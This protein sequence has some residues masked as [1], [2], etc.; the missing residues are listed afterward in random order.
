MPLSVKVLAEFRFVSLFCCCPGVHLSTVVIKYTDQFMSGLFFCSFTN[1]V[2]PQLSLWV[3]PWK[4]PFFNDDLKSSRNYKTEI[5][6]VLSGHRLSS[7]FHLPIA[8]IS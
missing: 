1:N 3:N 2:G 5:E 8:L 6:Y 7:M 4:N